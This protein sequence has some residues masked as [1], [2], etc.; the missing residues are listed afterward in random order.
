LFIAKVLN[1]LEIN[2]LFVVV[3]FFT[4]FVPRKEFGSLPGLF[5][6][7]FLNNAKQETCNAKQKWGALIF[8]AEI[9]PF[10]PARVIP[11]RE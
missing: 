1:F 9:I 10:E 3:P 4:I 2:V 11:G 5:F 7:L 6:F 8:Q